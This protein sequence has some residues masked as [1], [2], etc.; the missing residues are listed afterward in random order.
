[1]QTRNSV[2]LYNS[3]VYLKTICLLSLVHS[4]VTQSIFQHRHVKYKETPLAS[5]S[6]TFLL[7]LGELYA[8]MAS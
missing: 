4:L 3:N 6:V 5:P 1:M 8:N 7:I 2:E